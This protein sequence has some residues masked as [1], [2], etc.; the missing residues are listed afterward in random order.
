MRLACRT[1]SVK[2]AK[3]S[4]P[5]PRGTLAHSLVINNYLV[6][7]TFIVNYLY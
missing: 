2:T 3:N 1:I 4:S 5:R 6:C 7:K